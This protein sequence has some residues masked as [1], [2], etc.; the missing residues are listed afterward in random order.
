MSVDGW[1]RRAVSALKVGDESFRWAT[2]TNQ[3]GQG[4]R[5]V[6]SQ[7]DTP[8]K[9]RVMLSIDA[10]F[11]WRVPRVQT[12]ILG[13]EPRYGAS[14][15]AT[16]RWQLE[17]GVGGAR[18]V[19]NFDASKLQ[20][21]SLPTNTVRVL[22]YA[23]EGPAG[24]YDLDD[25]TTI[26]AFAFVADGNTSTSAAKYTTFFRVGESGSAISVEIPKGASAWRLAG[27][28][29]AA[30]GDP[31]TSNFEYR[32]V[33]EAG[34]LDSLK[35]D[36]L[37]LTHASDSFIPIPGSAGGSTGGMRILSGDGSLGAGSIIWQLDL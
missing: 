20:Q 15:I 1:I 6:G 24:N 21:V 23:N 36:Q 31:F 27:V 22:L 2:Q 35:G 11:P 18:S 37:L 9:P 8:N 17:S 7:F 16:F 29:G 19:F 12:L 30:P 26:D 3:W 4:R 32:I 25:T 13:C 5:F 14:Q 34:V 10:P 28:P 33:S